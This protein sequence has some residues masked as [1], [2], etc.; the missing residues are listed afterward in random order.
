MLGS[1]KIYQ[2]YLAA[3]FVLPFL[4]S[5]IFF[6]AF[7]L[8]FELFRVIQVF[9]A[10]DIS[11]V[12]I[13][14]MMGNIAIT[15]VPHALPLSVYFAAIS[16]VG[17]MSGDSEYIALRSF[18]LDKKHLLSPFIVIATLISINVYLMNHELVPRSHLFVRQAFKKISSTSL[19][20]GIK[21]GQFFTTIP[22][23]TM[24]SES[25]EEPSKK[26][27]NVFVQVYNPKEKKEKVIFSN[28]GQVLYAKNERTGIESFKLKLNNG[29]MFEVDET[30]KN[31]EKILFDEYLLPISEK[32]FSYRPSTVEIMMTKKQLRELI[33]GG[34]EKALK[35]NFS[36]RN[37]LNA[38]YEYWNRLITPILCLV[39]VFLG[40]CLGVKGNRSRGKNNSAKAIL[41]LV[42]YYILYFSMISVCRDNILP[43]EIGLFIPMIF[44]IA[45]SIN[46][47]RK[48]DW[49]S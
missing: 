23:L 14:K 4:V 38:Q 3:N 7:L 46:E 8:T 21:S 40:F 35:K 41:I 5:S 37:Y 42:G 2:F 30:G 44:L 12:F 26:L 49:Q 15:I 45:Y 22:N 48:L 31:S 6:V 10:S 24:F 34:L 11:F 33:D 20:E 32:R 43:F 19:V 17:R 9:T 16:T 13:L 39:L 27:K 25:V 18:G 47:Y 29:N 28:N 36:K 1:L